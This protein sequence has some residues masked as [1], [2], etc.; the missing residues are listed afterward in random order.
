LNITHFSL[1]ITH[2][3][4]QPTKCGSL[5]GKSPTVNENDFGRGRQLFG[6]SPTAIENDF[7]RYC[8]IKENKNRAKKEAENMSK[9]NSSAIQR[10]YVGTRKLKYRYTCEHC[11]KQTEYFDSTYEEEHV[12]TVKTSVNAMLDVKKIEKQAHDIVKKSTEAAPQLLETAFENYKKDYGNSDFH[13]I[14]FENDIIMTDIYNRTFK[15][16][17]TCP[18]CNKKQGWYPASHIKLS[19]GKKMLNWAICIGLLTLAVAFCVQSGVGGKTVLP[20]S[21]LFGG[22]GAVVGAVW[23]L[24]VYLTKR[25][26]LKK[27]AKPSV[28]EIEWGEIVITDSDRVKAWTGE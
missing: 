1:H 15:E 21:L 5:F 17:A 6:K 22:I 12:K 4:R 25:P 28:P 8:T 9:R 2:C 26:K 7:G 20:M 19:L 24:F 13:G 18:N 3:R 27:G 23:G 14:I 11:G 16:N 10:G